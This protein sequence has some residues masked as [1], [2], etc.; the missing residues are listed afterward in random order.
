MV[1]HTPPAKKLAT[2]DRCMLV[3]VLVTGHDQ[4]QERCDCKSP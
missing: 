2:D 3:M 1:I 4:N